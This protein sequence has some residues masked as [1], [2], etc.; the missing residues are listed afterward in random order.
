[1][2]RQLL[3]IAVRFLPVV[4]RARY[5]EE[6]RSELAEIALAGGGR[7]AQMAYAARTVLNSAWQLRA[8]LRSPRRRGAVQ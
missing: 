2:A 7:R 1:L 8:A 6:F 3:G 4:E 5:G